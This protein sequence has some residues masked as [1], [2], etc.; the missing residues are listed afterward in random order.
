MQ[1]RS[2]QSRIVCYRVFNDS[3]QSRVNYRDKLVA[4]ER[5][6]EEAPDVAKF[7]P[8]GRVTVSFARVRELIEQASAEGRSWIYD[9]SDDDVT[10]SQDLYEVLL[11]LCSLNERRAA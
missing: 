9:F 6:C 1:P 10:I 4:H 3:K 7:C 5:G 8:L 2:L 11:A